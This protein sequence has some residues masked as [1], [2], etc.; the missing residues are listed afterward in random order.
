MHKT[1]WKEVQATVT[2][3]TQPKQIHI[4]YAPRTGIQKCQW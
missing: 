2:A 4:N 1:N 3:L